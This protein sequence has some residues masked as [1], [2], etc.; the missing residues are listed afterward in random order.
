VT[1]S[2]TRTSNVALA[3]TAIETWISGDVEGT[4][5]MLSEEVEVFVPPE[6][7]NTGSFRGH[8]EFL[9]WAGD[10]NEA[11]ADLGLNVET[12]EPVGE[13]HVVAVVHQTATGRGS[14][15]PVEMDV[16]FL[17]EVRGGEIAAVHLYPTAEDA[18][19]VAEER[20]SQASGQ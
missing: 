10:W 3:R 5:A 18:R 20:E 17:T 7:A 14:G 16:A 1:D 8:Q 6:L 13:R 19:R 9:R 15:I 4:L 2:D 12:E 11:W